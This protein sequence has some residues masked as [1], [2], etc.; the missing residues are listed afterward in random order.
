MSSSSDGRNFETQIT[1]DPKGFEAGF[2]KAAA[3]ARA[4]S[5]QIKGSLS[6]LNNSFEGLNKQLLAVSAIVGGG[7]FFKE[8]IGVANKLN[9][10]AMGLAKSLGI[11]GTEASTLRTA[12]G[13]IG[14]DSETYIGAF[15]KFAKQIKTN[16]D[17]LKAMGLQTRDSNGN[18]RDSNTLFTDGLKVVGAYK[19]GLDQTTAAMTIFGK[20]VDEVMALQK[21]NNSVLDE[22]KQKNIDLGMTLSQEGVAASK[23]YKMAM[24]DVGDV[25]EA[26]K[27]TI[28]QAVMPIVT[29]LGEWFSEIGPPAVFAFRVAINAVATALQGLIGFARALW[30]V[31]RGLVNPLFEIGGA[32]KKLIEGDMSGATKQMQNAFGGWGSAISEGWTRAGDGLKRTASEISN[33]WGKGTDVAAPKTGTRTMGA[34]S[35]TNGGPAVDKSRTKE[36]D[37]E[38]AEDKLRFQEKKNLEGSFAQFTKQTEA[39][40]WRDKLALTT[41]GSA[42]NISVRK[43]MADLG[44]A[45]GQES[46]Q[47]ELAKLQAEEAGYKNNMDA[48]LAILNQEAAL[49]K[50]RFGSESKE[51]EDVQKNIVEAKRAA[52]E[53]LKQL[54]LQRTQ[55]AR[56]ASL[57][58][59]QGREQVAQL[60]LQL[61]VRTQLE[62]LAQQQQFEVE[63]H[64]IA[65]QALREREQIA[66]LDPDKNIVELGRI[67]QEIQQ[68]ERQ[69]QLALNGIRQQSVLESKKYTLDAINTMGSGFQHVFQQAIQGQL[70]LRGVMQGLWQSMVQAVSGALASIAA[71][72]ISTKIVEMIFGKTAAKAE[73]SANAGVAG[74]AAVASTAAIPIV[75]PALAPAAGAAASA[76]AMAF[77]ALAAAPGFA[78]GSWEVPSDMLTK[79]HKGE[80]IVPAQFAQNMREGGALGGGG[81]GD[82]APIHIHSTGGEFIHKNDL[83]K[84]LKKMNRN[85]QFV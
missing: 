54:D 49:V 47:H 69:H 8:A 30:D 81:G 12:L 63:K 33:L 44:L 57:A 66:A 45:I 41:A 55:G 20:G 77:G 11:T 42:E 15:Q 28:G 25:F 40:F 83:A 80:M 68:A 59:L 22:A 62:A 52:V 18:L 17:G 4:S 23:K 70:S 61:G 19:P 67:H 21:L 84:L 39:A 6:S 65:L 35:K 75:G 79:I 72:W 14:S 60:E 32:F 78:V 82:F 73:I 34:F 48:K 76:A 7:A 5:E 29:R 37:A 36:W 1:A 26:I 53:Q 24:N 3:A 2:A 71:K 46:Y 64:A 50:Q 9:G 16:E 58:E 74:A 51:Y 31:L 13:D 56:D 85:F 38:L 43:K 27:Y 10:E